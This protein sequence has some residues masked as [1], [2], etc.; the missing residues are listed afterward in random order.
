MRK[1]IMKS[2]KDLNNDEKWQAVVPY[3]TR[4]LAIKECIT[5]YKSNETKLKKKQ[6]TSYNVNYKTKKSPSQTFFVNKN[7]LKNGNL[8]VRRFKSKK[9]ATLR[10]RK[11]VRKLLNSDSEGDFTIQYH[12]NKWYVCLLKKNKMKNKQQSIINRHIVLCF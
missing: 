1:L 4:Q 8:F 3:D 2:D 10:T 7:A 6:I 9:Q 12:N 11:R 5:C